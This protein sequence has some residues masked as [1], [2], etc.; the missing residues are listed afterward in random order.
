MYLDDAEKTAL[1]AL[2]RETLLA[3]G[4]VWVTADV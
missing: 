4:G 3:R 2:V 1:A